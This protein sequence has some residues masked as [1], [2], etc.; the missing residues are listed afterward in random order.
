MWCPPNMFY[1]N[2]VYY[3]E[4]KL[5]VQEILNFFYDFQLTDGRKHDLYFVN[6]CKTNDLWRF[7]YVCVQV[8]YWDLTGFGAF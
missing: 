1:L 5:S 3:T 6:Y 7:L 4:K 8:A 2:P